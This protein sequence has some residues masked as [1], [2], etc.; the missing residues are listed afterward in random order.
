MRYVLC[1]VDSFFSVGMDQSMRTV[2]KPIQVFDTEEAADAACELFNPFYDY[3]L[4]VVR[5]DKLGDTFR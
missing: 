4:A 1:T 2:A 5:E 3:E